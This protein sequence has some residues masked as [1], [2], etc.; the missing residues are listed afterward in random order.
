M[1]DALV[2]RRAQAEASARGDL[3]HLQVAPSVTEI[4]GPRSVAGSKWG[5]RI[6]A[7]DGS[8]FS[9]DATRL[10]RILGANRQFLRPTQ[11]NRGPLGRRGARP[12]GKGGRRRR[13]CPVDLD[14][15]A[16]V[17]LGH[18]L[19]SRGVADSAR[20]CVSP[21]T[22]APAMKCPHR[23]TLTATQPALVRRYPAYERRAPRCGA[24]DS[25]GGDRHGGDVILPGRRESS[26]S[27]RARMLLE[28]FSCEE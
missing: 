23:A 4:S 12:S 22:T 16:V 5:C 9:P 2:A 3:Q 24:L 27:E 1:P 17:D 13:H 19:V 25:P 28:Q 11:E 10:G 7:R 14:R 18:D 21:D 8:A 6:R 26:S 15:P 20:P